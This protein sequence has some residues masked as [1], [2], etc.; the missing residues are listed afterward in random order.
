[1]KFPE[2][3]KIIKE[4]N[5]YT[6]DALQH[7]LEQ[8]DYEGIID[9]ADSPVCSYDLK[10]NMVV[11]ISS[12]ETNNSNSYYVKENGE[13]FTEA[14]KEIKFLQ[15]GTWQF[16]R[17]FTLQDFFDKYKDAPAIV[18]YPSQETPSSVFHAGNKIRAAVIKE[19]YTVEDSLDAN[20]EG[21]KL[22]E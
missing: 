9:F 21:E 15:M 3:Y 12:E 14:G 4:V 13:K 11:G 22:S 2:K 18:F 17:D 6:N 1:M 10:N 19:D 16:K 8:Y 5:P 20:T 7:E